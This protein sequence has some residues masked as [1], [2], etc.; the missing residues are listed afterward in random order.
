MRKSLY[1][2]CLTLL[3][4]GHCW[5]LD[6]NTVT[7]D[8]LAKTNAAQSCEKNASIESVGLGCIQFFDFSG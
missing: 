4:S 1:V 2:A 8:V 5:A 7:V 6:T 3:L